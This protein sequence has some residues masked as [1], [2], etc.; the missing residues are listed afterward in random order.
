MIS[1]P[2]KLAEFEHWKTFFNNSAVSSQKCDESIPEN[3]I[4]LPNNQNANL[5]FV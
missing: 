5:S 2:T 3:A 1:F 4:S